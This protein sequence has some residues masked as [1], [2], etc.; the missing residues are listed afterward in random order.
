MTFR[1]HG[2]P[3]FNSKAILTAAEF[4]RLADD[5]AAGFDGLMVAVNKAGVSMS[6]L[7]GAFATLPLAAFEP[8]EDPPLSRVAYEAARRGEANAMPLEEPM[9]RRGISLCGL[10]AGVGVGKADR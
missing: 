4:E 1:G 9:V 3:M 8:F 6:E 10:H 2:R 5:V 7:A